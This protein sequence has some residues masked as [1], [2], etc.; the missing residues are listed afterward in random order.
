MQKQGVEGTHL[1]VFFA[2]P[3]KQRT[4]AVDRGQN[5]ERVSLIGKFPATP[6]RP[7]HVRVEVGRHAGVLAR[8][9][10]PEPAL[11]RLVIS[12]SIHHNGKEPKA[13]DW[14]YV[15]RG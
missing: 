6:R 3:S 11:F 8:S 10:G 5:L 12:G 9:R 7:I 14:M 1:P 2:R 15:P 13:G 4:C